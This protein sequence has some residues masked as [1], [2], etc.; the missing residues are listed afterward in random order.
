MKTIGILIFLGVVTIVVHA[1]SN[2]IKKADSIASL[3]PG[4]SL[5]DLGLLSYKLTASLSGDRSKFRAIYKWVC[6]NIQGDYDLTEYCRRMRSKLRDERL[7]RW[8]CEFN[9][10][11]IQTLISRHRTICKGYSWLIRELALRA[12][13]N[14][15]IVHGY[16]RS[17]RSNIG[18]SGIV[19]HSWNA[20]MLDG[21]WYLCDPTWSSGVA[22]T[23]NEFTPSYID[24]YFLADP[25]WFILNHYPLNTQW[26]LLERA[27]ALQTFLDAPLI[28]VSAYKYKVRPIDPSTFKLE[29]TRD[30]ETSFSFI[31]NGILSTRTTTFSRKGTYPY[32][33]RINNEYV[34]SYKVVVK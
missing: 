11:V 10:V 17:V 30:R 6:T 3:Y 20:V 24:E 4:H 1:Q 22:T 31:E 15:E 29:T 32:H 27:P 14:C 5:S 25:E 26:T 34:V 12:G 16:A 8:S 28:Y 2:E 21:K 7:D 13:I 9:K 19:N 23:E 33:I 18:G